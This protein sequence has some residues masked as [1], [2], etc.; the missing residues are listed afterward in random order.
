VKDAGARRRAGEAALDA[1][2][3]RL[4]RERSTHREVGDLY[5]VI[6]VELAQRR[7]DL[8]ATS[9]DVEL[10]ARRLDQLNQCLTGVAQAMKEASYDANSRVVAT[11]QSV[12]DVCAAARGLTNGPPA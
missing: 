2:I 10:R 8:N 3:R 12:A 9:S 5:R 6:T 1:T 11:L 7:K 4:Q